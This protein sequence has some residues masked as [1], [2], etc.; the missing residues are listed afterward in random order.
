[1]GL[2][3][4]PKMLVRNYHYTLCNSPEEHSAYLLHSGSLRSCS[5]CLIVGMQKHVNHAFLYL[6]LHAVLGLGVTTG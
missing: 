5:S 4:F 3:G 2:I 6:I 1:M